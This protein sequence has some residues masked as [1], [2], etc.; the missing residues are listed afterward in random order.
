MLGLN[1]QENFS[2]EIINLK[3]YL[4]GSY[5]IYRETVNALYS[6]E[7]K[8]ESDGNVPKDSLFSFTL[9]KSSR[10][11]TLLLHSMPG[12]TLPLYIEYC[13]RNMLP[14]LSA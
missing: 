1:A 5:S 6:I 11:S 7:F 2:K 8:G 9:Q 14:L 3:D 13:K 10:Y 4:Y 12:T